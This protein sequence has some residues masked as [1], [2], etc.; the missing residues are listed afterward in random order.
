MNNVKSGFVEV[1]FNNQMIQ[2]PKEFKV[3][4]YWKL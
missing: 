1:D 2:F 3:I 4:Y